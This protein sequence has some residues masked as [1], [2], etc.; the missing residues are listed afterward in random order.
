MTDTSPI[1]TVVD[2]GTGNILSVTRALEHVG[3]STIVTDSPTVIDRA[4]QILLPGV[5]AFGKAMEELHSRGLVGPLQDFAN[6]GR[7]FLGICLGMQLMMEQSNEFGRHEG[8]GL[9]SGSVEEIPR[10]G[11]DG[12]AHKIP[13]IGW[14]ALTAPSRE[15]WD[16]SCLRN[17]A[18]GTSMYFVHSFTVVPSDIGDRLADTDYDGCKISAAIKRGNLTGFQCHPEKSGPAGLA[19]L[20]TFINQN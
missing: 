17:T 10:N 12:R 20:S 5:G 1:V 19:I 16:E 2:Y 14:N 7:P 15:R 8:L 6:S 11:A 4:Q 18:P 9:V 3:A 13:H